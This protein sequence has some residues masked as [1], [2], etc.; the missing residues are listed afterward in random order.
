MIYSPEGYAH[1]LADKLCSAGQRIYQRAKHIDC[2]ATLDL[3]SYLAEWSC[4]YDL[5]SSSTDETCC[6]W[7]RAGTVLLLNREPLF[8][9][10]ADIMA[11]VWTHDLPVAERLFEY[12]EKHRLPAGA[13]REPDPDGQVF[14]MIRTMTGFD[15]R[16]AGRG[17]A[18]LV[19]D[20]YAPN[21]LAQYDA[22]VAALRA[23]DP[24]GRLILLNGPPGTGK[25]HMVRAFMA[26]A[27][28]AKFVVIPPATIEHLGNPEWITAL[29]REQAD[30]GDRVVIVLE[31]ADQ[32]VAAR[33][34]ASMNA[35]SAVLNFSD[36]LLGQLFDVMIIASTNA[37]IDKFDPAILRS[38]RMAAHV[39][40][41]GL[42]ADQAAQIY[43]RLCGRTDYRVGGQTLAEVYQAARA[44]GQQ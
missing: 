15:F 38:G 31:D 7:T 43:T 20:N 40:L 41:A 29:I 14:L 11:K 6:V 42:G 44:G 34:V 2:A 17:G 4:G 32:C 24:A 26:V 19:R 8:E 21:A 36:G 37:A 35:I 5:S 27:P 1:H 9:G 13:P 28:A 12:L 10:A 3:P 18:P 22:A 39:Q 33:D 25:T 16:A 23:K 30:E